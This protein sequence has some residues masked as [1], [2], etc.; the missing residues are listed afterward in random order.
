[1]AAAPRWKVYD[2]HGEYQAACK[3]IAAAASLMGFYGDGATIHD[4]HDSRHV[5]VEGSEGISA[6]ESYDVVADLI[7]ERVAR[8]SAEH[9]SAQIRSP[10]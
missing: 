10:R 7:T 9:R 8:R 4:G 1:M 2:S 3:E 6:L 5:W